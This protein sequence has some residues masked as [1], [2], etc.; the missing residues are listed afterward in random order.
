MYGFLRCVTLRY[1]RAE[2]THQILL[3]SPPFDTTTSDDHR[4]SVIKDLPQAVLSVDD[5]SII[6]S[7][8]T[9]QR[10]IVDKTRIIMLS[11]S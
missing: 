10:N 3:L 6:G 11:T 4:L 8:A 9:L 7:P 1:V 2:T 5:A